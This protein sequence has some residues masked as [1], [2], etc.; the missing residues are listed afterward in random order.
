MDLRGTVTS[1]SQSTG[2]GDNKTRTILTISIDEPIVTDAD[3]SEA[4]ASGVLTTRHDARNAYRAL[5]LGDIFLVQ[6]SATLG[7][8]DLEVKDE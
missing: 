2:W 1:I 3:N 7:V 8:D 5:H 6:F 4:I